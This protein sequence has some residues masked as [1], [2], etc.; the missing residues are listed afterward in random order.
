[1]SKKRAAARKPYDPPPPPPPPLLDTLGVRIA[2]LPRLLRM[3][4]AAL[5]SAVITG[6][7]GISAFTLLF[8]LPV[9][10]L[11][12]NILT[13]ML[14]GLAAVGV[15]MYWVGWRVMLGF[16]FEEEPLQ[17][18]RAAVLWLGFGVL[19][20]IVAVVLSIVAALEATGPA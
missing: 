11:P 3:A 4:L 13:L 7:I 8:Q 5:V 18:G 10:Q 2:R 14:I 17:P 1:M 12:E 15:V 19:V 16:D 6:A 20:L 9:N